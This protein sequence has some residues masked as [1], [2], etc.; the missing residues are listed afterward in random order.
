MRIARLNYFRI[1]G[2]EGSLSQSLW[3]VD[4]NERAHV[5][6]KTDRLVCRILVIAR[7][8][9]GT[10]CFGRQRRKRV[11]QGL[12]SHTF[13][14]TVELRDAAGLT[15]FPWTSQTRPR[16]HPLV[17]ASSALLVCPGGILLRCLQ[18]VIGLGRRKND[19]Q[20]CRRRVSPAGTR[21]H[22]VENDHK[23][24][25][26]ALTAETG[27]VNNPALKGSEIATGFHS[28]H[29]WTSDHWAD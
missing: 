20:E 10:P 1:R 7:P 19:W 12:V 3:A 6:L 15:G 24:G 25:Q 18:R 4:R 17:R 8:R 11:H 16:V 27:S 22:S 28:P 5:R 13:I 2:H 21:L 29:Y 26:N 14:G 23:H 9:P